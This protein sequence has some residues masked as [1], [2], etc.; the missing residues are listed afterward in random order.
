MPNHDALP[1]ELWNVVASFTDDLF[2]LAQVAVAFN[3][4]SIAHW[5]TRQGTTLGQLLAGDVLL[6]ADALRALVLYA[7]LSELPATKL[8]IDLG[9]D[10]SESSLGSGSRSSLRRMRELIR[11]A[12]HLR[13]LEIDLRLPSYSWRYPRSLATD[14]LDSALFC[15]ALST[16]AA[17]NTGPVLILGGNPGPSLAFTCWPQDIKHWNL[18]SMRYNAPTQW[19]HKIPLPFKRKLHR[20]WYTTTRCHDGSLVRVGHLYAPHSVQLHLEDGPAGHS[21]LIFDAPR[22]GPFYAIAKPVHG[23]QRITPAVAGLLPVFFRTAKL[24]ALRVFS[25]ET[26]VDPGTI[27]Q[28]LVKNPRLKELTFSWGSSASHGPP[29]VDPLLSH[30]GLRK[31]ATT[32]PYYV[33][34]PPDPAHA[35]SLLRGLH[36]SPNLEKIGFHVFGYGTPQAASSP[37]DAMLDEL[38][39][40]AERPANLP[41]ISLMLTLY[42]TPPPVPTGTKSLLALRL[43]KLTPTAHKAPWPTF[44]PSLEIAASLENIHELFINTRSVNFVYALLPWLAAL[45]A[46]DELEI[47]DL[48]GRKEADEADEIEIFMKEAR[49]VLHDE[50]RVRFRPQ[51]NNW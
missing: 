14:A 17:R 27:R 47:F 45:P 16:A 46:L 6:T 25:L 29:L 15:A 22:I 7:P 18:N 12:P 42:W 40:L 35:S 49:R 20:S 11:R 9:S 21:L 19:Y 51:A 2:V 50:T 5:A 44:S 31:L 10:S 4:A 43:P 33:T 8:M 39:C 38:Q 36:L 26:N 48:R 24:P 3:T 32:V 41:R 34:S 30:P 37:L 23:R 1:P 13:D 28:F